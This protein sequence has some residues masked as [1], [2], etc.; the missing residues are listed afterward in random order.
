MESPIICASIDVTAVLPGTVNLK[1]EVDRLTSM[2]TYSAPAGSLACSSARVGRELCALRLPAAEGAAQ[3]RGVAGE[4]E[5]DLLAVPRG[6]DRAYAEAMR[7]DLLVG[8]RCPPER[9]ALP[10]RGRSMPLWQC[11]EEQED[12]MYCGL[13][14]TA[15][16]VNGRLEILA[17]DS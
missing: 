12:M 4:R 11:L 3:A 5:A 10:L 14:E 7:T 16:T 6:T 13:R 9:N 1:R 17:I 8:T 2:R 15:L